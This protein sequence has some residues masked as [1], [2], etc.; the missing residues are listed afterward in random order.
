MAAIAA[1]AEGSNSYY[2]SGCFINDHSPKPCS[3]LEATCAGLAAAVID[4]NAQIIIT[5]TTFGAPAR[6]VS[7]YRPPVPQI[8][9][10]A[11][12]TVARQTRVCF[13]QFALLVEGGLGQDVNELVQKAKAYALSQKI[14]NGKG[15]GL[16][17]HGRS[18]PASDLQ[19]VYRAFELMPQ[20][21][22]SLRSFSLGV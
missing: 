18:E 7:K 22:V 13:G 4:C 11:D 9:V 3:R 19:P 20:S 10:T 15:T 12:P 1:N 17:L 2:S 14:W 6:M 21:R 16:M 8:V 5:I